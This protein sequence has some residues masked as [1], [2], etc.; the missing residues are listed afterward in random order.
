VRLPRRHRI[1][2]DSCDPPRRVNP[3][4]HGSRASRHGAGPP[5]DAKTID[6][7]TEDPPSPASVSAP[8]SRVRSF[9][10]RGSR[11]AP[12]SSVRSTWASDVTRTL[13]RSSLSPS[14]I[15]FLLRLA[16]RKTGR[17]VGHRKP[18]LRRAQ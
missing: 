16:S 15:D 13:R 12:T 10:T 2:A 7:R 11:L 1:S 8:L 14:D 17:R 5:E 4:S 3:R 18:T 9:S 6:T